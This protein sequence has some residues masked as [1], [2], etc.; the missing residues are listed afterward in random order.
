MVAELVDK[1]AIRFCG[2]I[3]LLPDLPVA[4]SHCCP[5]SAAAPV[6]EDQPAKTLN[7]VT[8]PSTRAYHT[9]V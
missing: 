8:R 6:V 1:P 5:F 2:P 9:D 3:C 7:I 4:R